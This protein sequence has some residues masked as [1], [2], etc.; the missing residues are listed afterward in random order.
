LKVTP[1]PLE[2]S[3]L[4]FEAPPLP[5]VITRFPALPPFAFVPVPAPPF[6]VMIAGELPIPAIPVGF[7]VAP[8]VTPLIV[9]SAIAFAPV[10][11]ET[12]AGAIPDK[13]KPAEAVFG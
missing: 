8:P 7:D 11:V 2:L 9:R 4:P 13:V 1:P 3:A 5:V 12:L 6:P 10:E